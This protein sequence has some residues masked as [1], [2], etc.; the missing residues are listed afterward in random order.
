MNIT[1]STFDDIDEVFRLYR[2]ASEYQ[3]TKYIVQWPEFERK[4]IETEIKEKRQWKILVDNNF[5][6]TFATTFND[7][8]IWQE[9][10][11]DDS[12][13]IHR[14]ATN[15]N[16]R[17]NNFVIDIVR[18][19]KLY[20]NQNNKK[21]IRLDTVGDNKK[22]I[23]HYKKCGF[24]FLGFKELKNTKGLPE[25]YDLGPVALFEISLEE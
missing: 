24:S 11:K 10:D 23:E 16:Y 9:K 1:N 5:A 8:L 3:K 17:G 25:H 14:I 20:A 18:W 13:F 7:P 12:I 19:A 15:P 6:C 22:L 4:L 21:F 2:I